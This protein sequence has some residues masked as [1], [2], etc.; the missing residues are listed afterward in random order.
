MFDTMNS[1][2]NTIEI[3]NEALSIHSAN[4]ANMSVPGYKSLDISFQ[5]ILDRLMSPGTAA[6]TFSNQ[7]GTNPI[8]LGQ[9]TAISNIGV[10]FTQGSFSQTNI[11]TDLAITG[12]GLMVVSDDGGTTYKYT[13]AGKFL[14][15]SAG[16]LTTDK[17]MQVYGLDN[18]GNL[19][20]ITGLSGALTEYS[21]NNGTGA[22]LHNGA[23]TGYRIALT[24]FPNESGL[25][26][27]TG[28][29]FTETA[30][31]GS[32][33]TPIAV[34]GI[35]GTITSGS[36]EQSNVFY[37]GESIESLENQRVISA[38]LNV[39]KA[40]SDLISQFISKLG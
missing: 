16:A 32:A 25:A 17:G 12:R 27:S 28:T 36:I 26:Q 23:A 35:A 13:R 30:A 39:V 21:W 38:N 1:A 4:I 34:G 29:T 18:S 31:S 6:S 9:G 37:L 11:N 33:A 10:N 15:N 19:I 40:A 22:L 5:T 3:Y 24:Y 20:A 7:G 8:Q 2:K 14:I